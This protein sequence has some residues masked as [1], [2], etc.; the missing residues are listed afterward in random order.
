MTEQAVERGIVS[1]QLEIPFEVRKEMFRNGTFMGQFADG[2][3]NIY[4]NAVIPYYA[5]EY[6]QTASYIDS[7]ANSFDVTISS[8]QEA[9]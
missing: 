2:I 8:I 9:S 1:L 3:T 5:N 4:Q 7:Y 6:Q